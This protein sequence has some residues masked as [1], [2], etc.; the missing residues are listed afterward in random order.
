MEVG[1]DLMMAIRK[2]DKGRLQ[3][4]TSDSCSSAGKKTT[5]L[6]KDREGKLREKRKKG[7]SLDGSETSPIRSVQRKI[8][9][10]DSRQ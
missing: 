7:K 10:G 6:I 3:E 9:E 4:E 5:L 2:K 8:L 1:D